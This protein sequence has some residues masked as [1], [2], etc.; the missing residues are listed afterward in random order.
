MPYHLFVQSFAPHEEGERLE[1]VEDFVNPVT[2]LARD[3]FTG[4]NS[5]NVAEA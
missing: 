5:A 1:E 3:K 4:G 2:R